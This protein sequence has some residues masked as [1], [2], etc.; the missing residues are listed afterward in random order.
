MSSATA[1][2]E[3]MG[4]VT[5]AATIESLKNLWFVET[6]HLPADQARRVTVPS[7]LVDTG[8]ITLSLPTRIIK[9]LGLNKVGKR[10]TMTT[11]GAREADLYDAVR[12]TVQ[13]R[14]CTIDVIE[15]PDQVPVLIGQVPLELLDFVVDPSSRKLIGNPE[16]GGHHMFEMY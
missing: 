13:D 6:G 5:T 2:A 12:L 4:R 10:E 8:T 1:G 15:V 7:A 14:S 11:A 3:I 9:Q 16:H